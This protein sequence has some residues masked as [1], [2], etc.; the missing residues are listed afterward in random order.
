RGKR[1][2]TVG[3]EAADEFL[4]YYSAGA[5]LDPHMADQIALYLALCNDQSVFTTSAVT[6]H[7]IT[8]LWV[9]EKFQPFKYSVAGEPGVP[10]VVR[11]N[12]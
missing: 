12:Y 3:E 8:N 10:G 2:E 1:A 6:D 7:L 4:K 5:A 11:I 9:I